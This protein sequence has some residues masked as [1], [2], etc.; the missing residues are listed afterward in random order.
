MRETVCL[1]VLRMSPAVTSDSSQPKVA[2]TIVSR[3]ASYRRDSR[4]C[5]P[6]TSVYA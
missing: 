2:A 1:G 6:C 3:V 4:C 5:P